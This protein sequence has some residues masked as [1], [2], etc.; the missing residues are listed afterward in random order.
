MIVCN[1]PYIASAELPALAPEVRAFDPRSALD[2]GANGLDYY[3]ALSV[4]V[5]ALL[6]S[7]GAVVVE[8]GFGQAD[9]VARLFSV[10]GLAVVPPHPDL[11]G[12]PRALLARKANSGS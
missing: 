4:S 6:R 5:P 3:R 7:G 2:G 9:A 12:V 1:P 10:A 11:N 8:I